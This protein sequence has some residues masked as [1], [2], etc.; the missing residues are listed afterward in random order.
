M[1]CLLSIHDCVNWGLWWSF[2]FWN[3]KTF[4]SSICSLVGD[5]IA[6]SWNQ[7]IVLVDMLLILRYT[8]SVNYSKFFH[9]NKKIIKCDKVKYAIIYLKHVNKNCLLYLLD[10]IFSHVGIKF[11][12]RYMRPKI[13]S[14][15]R[16]IDIICFRPP[17]C[18]R[19][20][21]TEISREQNS[22]FQI[23]LHSNQNPSAV[24]MMWRHIGLYCW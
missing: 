18:N 19:Q 21:L 14:F 10:D 20:N 11:T 6:L 3:N 4:I 16:C 1:Y 23:Y 8:F 7:F 24:H 22:W 5:S 12:F 2:K 9:L 15:E 17:S 13:R